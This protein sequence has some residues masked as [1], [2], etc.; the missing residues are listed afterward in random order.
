MLSFTL[1]KSACTPCLGVGLTSHKA[2]ITYTPSGGSRGGKSG[3]GPPIEVG[4][5]AWPPL[6]AEIAMVEL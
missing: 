1:E 2:L 4:N 6:G 3:H 5:G